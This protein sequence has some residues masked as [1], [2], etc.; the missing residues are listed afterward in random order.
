MEQFRSRGIT[1]PMADYL[2]LKQDYEIA[3][4]G[5]SGVFFGNET[6]KSLYGETPVKSPEQIQTENAQN[7]LISGGYGITK[8]AQGN[9]VYTAPSQSD[10]YNKTLDQ[11]QAQIDALDRLYATKKAEMTTQ[12]ATKSTGEIGSQRAIMAGAGMLGQVSGMAQKSNLQT[13]Q[14][15]RLK[16]A[17]E[18]LSAE[19]GAKK[20][21]LYGNVRTMAQN[22][23]NTKMN[24]YTGGINTVL[25]YL[26][27]QTA[28]K[29]TNVS[30]LVKTAIL[31]GIDLSNPKDE[32]LV[33]YAEGLNVP[34][35]QI[36]LEY[37]TQKT[38]FDAEQLKAQQEA[39]KAQVALE[40]TQSETAQNLA[41]TAQLEY[42]RTHPNIKTDSYTDAN[43]NLILYNVETGN[44]IKNLGKVAVSGTTPAPVDTSALKSTIKEIDTLL[45][46]TALNKVVGKGMG[47]KLFPFAWERLG[48]PEKNYIAGIE[49]MISTGTL[50]ALI[51]AK[52]QGATFGALSDA[53]LE[54]LGASFSKIKTWTM[55]NDNNKVLG[56]SIDKKSFENELKTIKE[57]TQRLLD[58]MGGNTGN[59]S[60]GL[61]TNIG[62]GLDLNQFEL[63]GNAASTPNQ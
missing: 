10:I 62:G 36:V 45:T 52:A 40:K 30:N 18:G 9:Y 59:Q 29:Q 4:T 7:A 63:G 13:E 43:G 24:A 37:T 58:S 41:Q 42:E 61:N 5:T 49:K 53:E 23:Y 11:F 28:N 27:N 47:T 20:E 39:E 46:D 57:S 56:Y 12:L 14:E 32:W 19:L 17:E 1:E 33:K 48:Y 15:A 35:S 34:A 22:E 25:E 8:D 6:M 44:V 55:V 3:N 38:A 54:L 60:G 26:K 31:N 2:K 51:S 21:A 16:T 50:N